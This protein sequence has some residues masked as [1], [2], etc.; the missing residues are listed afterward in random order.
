VVAPP[1]TPTAI[2]EQVSQAIA[3]SLRLPD[4][5]KRFSDLSAT[6]VGS[7]PSATAA[8]LKQETERWR[9]V[10]LSARIKVD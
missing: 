8:F 9:K 3:E 10:I 6:P 4:V 2:A 5:A 7:S 1:K